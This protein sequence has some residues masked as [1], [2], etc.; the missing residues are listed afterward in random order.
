MCLLSFQVMFV[1][2]SL[3]SLQDMTM[4]GLRMVGTLFFLG[5]TG[6]QHV[7]SSGDCKRNED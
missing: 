4:W 2:L 5:E 1:E 7:S 3:Q 6:L